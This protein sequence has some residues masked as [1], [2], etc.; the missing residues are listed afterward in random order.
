MDRRE[1]IF[2]FLLCV[3]KECPT[4]CPPL[5][6]QTSPSPSLNFRAADGKGL[7]VS[8]IACLD[9]LVTGGFDMSG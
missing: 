6:Q 8:L 1:C 3:S 2:I 5:P 9:G 4:T 7:G